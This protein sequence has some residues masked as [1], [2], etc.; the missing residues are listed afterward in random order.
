MDLHFNICYFKNINF[1]IYFIIVMVEYFLRK[2]FL[3]H[4]KIIL[5]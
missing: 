3:E 4:L 2:K 5:V 1:T